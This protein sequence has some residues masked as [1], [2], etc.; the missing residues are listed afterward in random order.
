MSTAPAGLMDDGTPHTMVWCATYN[1]LVCHIQWF[2]VPHIMV[3]CATYKVVL[4]TLRLFAFYTLLSLLF[5]QF[6]KP[7]ILSNYMNGH[8]YWVAGTTELPNS[9]NPVQCLAQ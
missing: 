9:D 7:F 8:S 4:L 3:R 2:G 1:G 5:I 6:A